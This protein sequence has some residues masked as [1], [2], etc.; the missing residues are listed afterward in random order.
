MATI[1]T[2][3][4]LGVHSFYRTE[5]LPVN[6]W[7]KIGLCRYCA[8][9]FDCGP[10]YPVRGYITFL[11]PVNG[12]NST[13]TYDQ[14]FCGN[15]INGTIEN[16]KKKYPPNKWIKCGYKSFGGGHLYLYENQYP[17]DKVGLMIAGYCIVGVCII[18]FIVAC[19]YTSYKVRNEETEHWFEDY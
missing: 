7:A 4:Y 16:G 10:T 19:C 11:F 2:S 13:K 17:S 6:Y 5:C 1:G 3:T 9:I 8:N 14:L 12:K 18:I 15:S